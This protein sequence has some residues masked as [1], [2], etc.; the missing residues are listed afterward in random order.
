ME[1][2][3]DSP[4][5]SVESIVAILE[6]E[7]ETLGATCEHHRRRNNDGWQD[8]VEVAF[9]TGEQPF[10]MTLWH[11]ESKDISSGAG[12]FGKGSIDALEEWLID[13]RPANWDAIPRTAPYYWALF[14]SG[15]DYS[16]RGDPVCVLDEALLRR[17]L[18]EGL[19]F[20][21]TS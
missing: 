21:T 2:A 7:A 5:N 9:Q 11:R 20:Y 13:L 17:L 8:T 4:E 14:R 19:G 6:D 10:R 15:Y 12:P 1:L 3:T 16:S 18:Q